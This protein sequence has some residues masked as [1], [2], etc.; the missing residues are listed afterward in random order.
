MRL[1]TETQFRRDT[2]FAAKSVRMTVDENNIQH[3]MS[4]LT[5]LYSDPM[6]A[7]IREYSTNAHDSHIAA[8]NDDPIEVFLPGP[9][10]RTFKVVDKGVGMSVDDLVNVYSK[11]GLSTKRDN[12]NESGMLGLGCKAGLTYTDQFTVT[13]V[14]DGVKTVAI[15]ARGEDGAG[16][17]D[18]VDTSGTDEDNGVTITVPVKE[19]ST[20]NMRAKEFFRFW[21]QGTVMVDGIEPEPLDGLQVTDDILV[22]PS[23][24]SQD[25]V[26]MGNIGY[27]V[28][29]RLSHNLPFEFNVVA[30]VHMGDVNF[31]PNREALHYTPRTEK[32]IE[33]IRQNMRA[34]IQASAQA[35]VDKA[36]THYDAIKAARQ[37]KR[38]SGMRNFTYKGEE[39]PFRFDGEGWCYNTN[40]YRY[41]TN[42]FRT[43]DEGTLSNA[44]QVYNY[45]NETVSSQVRK[46]AR[47]W[48]D[49][50]NID[51]KY[52]VFT[53]NR[54]GGKWMKDMP[55]VDYADVK[56]IKLN[57]R[58]GN[59][60][61]AGEP[62]SYYQNG[63]RAQADVNQIPGNHKVL[64]S[65]AQELSGVELSTF[66]PDATLVMLNKN[67]WD[68]FMRENAGTKVI[69]EAL[70]EA[71]EKIENSLTARE[72]V[73]VTGEA[74]QLGRMTNLDP[75]RIRDPELAQLI[76]DMSKD[77][78]RERLLRYRRVR[79]TL[80]GLGIT[81]DR[82]SG[83]VNDI[84]DTY[85]FLRYN[86]GVDEEHIYEYV[87][88]FYE[89]ETA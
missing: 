38:L 83:K 26:V 16:V 53:E 77:I 54:I 8:G 28:G 79:N 55:A 3:I 76:R 59:R 17:I 43:V 65:S 58:K 11:Y 50:N 46:K 52:I 12:D 35:E 44:I 2:N 61:A 68:K 24:L 48:R 74:Y 72:L 31:T 15:V 21:E 32:S 41:S 14:K 45:T 18:I 87:N 47:V 62:I 67:R 81:T 6:L 23:G 25:Y 66:M 9:F 39:I 69:D 19:S 49:E 36:E 5:D 70:K 33:R 4:V 78:D 27:G 89:K 82:P 13:A 42:T 60:R 7:V 22:T 75:A 57:Q 40:A 88:H 10:E 29:S 85:P 30:R 56:A 73:E 34:G 1:N 63:V 64:F 20:F 51:A 71:L 84:L 37:W 86:D 80:N